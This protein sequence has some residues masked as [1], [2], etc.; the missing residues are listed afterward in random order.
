MKKYHWSLIS[1]F[2][3]LTLAF[4]KLGVGFL[5]KS[6]ALK[7]E[8]IHSL[9]DSLASFIGFISI[10]IS[11]KKHERFPYGLYK[12]ENIGAM[13][14][15]FFLFFAAY[16]MAIDVLF[17]HY[18]I[19]KQYITWGLAVGIL[20]MVITFGFSFLERI[21]AKK[22]NS[23]A[24][25]A[26]SEHMLVD[27]FGAFVITL[28]FLS[29]EFNI[30]LDK[31]FASI[32]IL[33]IIY[34]GFHILKEQIFVI[35]DASVD[36]KMIEHIKD[37]ILQD[38]R[39]KSVKRLLVRKS[40]DKIFIDAAI[41]IK[42]HNFNQS[43]AVVDD[44]EEAITKVFPQT[45]MV[46]IHY[47]PDDSPENTRIAVLTNKDL[48][49]DFQNADM[50][51]VY[52]NFVLTSVL[53]AKDESDKKEDITANDIAQIKSDFVISS[54]HPRSNRAKWTL[55]KYGVFIWETDNK[56]VQKA[57]DEIKSFSKD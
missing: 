15:S 13:F 40:G 25:M 7:A 5:S 11:E 6:V 32:I 42:S 53:K 47:E 29:L 21:A 1:I 3:M 35:L 39:V 8:G 20:S 14:I 27:G 34:T 44:I 17:G 30:N 56:D 22:H 38:P 43:H 49:S 52:D 10:Y 51:H 9:S 19:D 23:P 18:K 50:I 16:D 57:L 46:F 4:I 55:H 28:N 31:F 45:E 12:L 37:V 26:D 33:L 2:L 24:L 41:S 54:N 36:S 48:V